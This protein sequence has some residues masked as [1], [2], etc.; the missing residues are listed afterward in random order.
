MNAKNLMKGLCLYYNGEWSE[1]KATI[2]RNI[3]PLKNCSSLEEE[4]IESVD[5]LT[6]FDEKYPRR[7]KDLPEPEDEKMPFGLFYK[8]DINLINKEGILAVIGDKRTSEYGIECCK[9]MLNDLSKNTTIITN[10]D[11]GFNE[12]II[13]ESINH[14]YKIIAVANS[15]LGSD[16]YCKDLIKKIESTGGLVI[17]E[18]PEHILPEKAHTIN[19]NRIVAYL[20]ENLLLI[21]SRGRSTC[22]NTVLTAI[23]VGKAIGI[24]PSPVIEKIES[25]ED[26]KEKWVE[27]NSNNNKL[28]RDGACIVSS[29]EDLLNLGFAKVI[30]EQNEK[31]GELENE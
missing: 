7:L 15:G 29:K 26:H 2:K 8:G 19:S 12:T 14:G 5:M 23:H 30:K 18:Y 17:S 6:I 21:E 24:I 16:S 27:I 13:N 22:L 25:D 11:K 20:C 31:E 9:K 28:I 3:N 4:Y 10:L 1:I